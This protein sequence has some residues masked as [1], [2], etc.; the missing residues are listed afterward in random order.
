MQAVRMSSG[1]QIAT[2]IS[3]PFK[4]PSTGRLSML[5]C[6]RVA[7]PAVQPRLR[8]SLEGRANGETFFRS[9]EVGRSAPNK[10]A[11]QWQVF[12]IIANDLPLDGVSS[13]QVRFDLIGSG[14]VWIDDIQL[15]ALAFS[16]KEQKELARLIAPAAVKLQQ[17]QIADCI[18]VL[19]GY[20][21][22]FL[23]DHVPLAQTPISRKTESGTNG[24]RPRETSEQP[25]GILGRMKG[26]LPKALR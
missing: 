3:Q 22:H 15:R 11:G 5:V 10:I 26:W 21:P 16:D 17:A 12:E 20:W 1:G 24:P 18:H 4:V 9:S 2:L 8:L 13:L 23:E 7:D 19:E 25:N 6:L 14:D